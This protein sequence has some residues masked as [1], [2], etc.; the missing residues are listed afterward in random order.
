MTLDAVLLD[1]DFTLV[2]PHAVFDA[3]GYVALGE[4]V[5][6]TLDAG[7]YE[8]ARHH[9][10]HVWERSSLEHASDEHARFARE[11]VRGMGANE[12][13]AGQ[14]GAV[15]EEEWSNPANFALFDDVPP[16]FAA[17]RERGLAIGLISNTSRDLSAFALALGIEAD[18][19]LSSREHG[20]VKP[21]PTI[22]SAAI[23]RAGTTVAHALMVGDS[24]RDDIGGAEAVGL[25][26][27]L[28]DRTD[29]YPDHPGERIRTLAE[30]PELLSV[31][32]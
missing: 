27:V 20:R 6:A 21:C 12:L 11:I 7:R 4:R 28:V 9:A 16:L 3:A 32:R 1:V 10:L 15:A 26:A 30:L 2:W 25:R 19:V 22:F 17:L 29:R 8:A 5:G 14:I 13:E 18:F 24:V 23:E 31:V